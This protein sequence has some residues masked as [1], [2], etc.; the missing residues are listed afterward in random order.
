MDAAFVISRGFAW[1]RVKDDTTEPNFN[2]QT[3]TPQTGTEVGFSVRPSI[4]SMH[5]SIKQESVP[6]H[7]VSRSRPL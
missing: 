4:C 7:V 5:L 1:F 6:L 2:R 3:S